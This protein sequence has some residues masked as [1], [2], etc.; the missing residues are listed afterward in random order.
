MTESI[1]A[2]ILTPSAQSGPMAVPMFPQHNKARIEFR[3]VGGQPNPVRERGFVEMVGDD[4]GS[5]HALAIERDTARNFFTRMGFS[6]RVR[7]GEAPKEG[8]FSNG[9]LDPHAI[10][11]ALEGRSGFSIPLATLEPLFPPLVRWLRP[12]ANRD[13]LRGADMGLARQILGLLREGRQAGGQTLLFL[14]QTIEDATI[15]PHG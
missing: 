13:D 4:I 5:L 3:G 11:R 14:P 8:H 15:T 12:D 10:S 2:W 6:L 9:W 1:E 7:Q